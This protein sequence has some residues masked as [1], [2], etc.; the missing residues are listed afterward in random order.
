MFLNTAQ[1]TS[2]SSFLDNCKSLLTPSFFYGLADDTALTNS[3]IKAV[4]D[5]FDRFYSID[6]YS[7]NS[8]TALSIIIK[9]R[10]TLSEIACIRYKLYTYAA[11]SIFHENA[12]IR[13]KAAITQGKSVISD[14]TQSYG[15]TNQSGGGFDEIALDYYFMMKNLIKKLYQYT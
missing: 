4:E 8:S 12:A 14:G 13:D 15:W 9:Q 3:M 6:T 2:I 5:S 10:D 7:F 1:I 11:L